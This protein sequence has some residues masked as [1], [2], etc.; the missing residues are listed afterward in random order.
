VHTLKTLSLVLLVVLVFGLSTAMAQS[1]SISPPS[2]SVPVANTLQFSATTSGI[3]N[4][5]CITFPCYQVRWSVNGIAGGNSTV[6]TVGGDGLYTAPSAVPNP[7]TVTV[8]ATSISMPTKSASATVTI[9]ASLVQVSI[10]PTTLAA[11]LGGIY[12]FS[13]TVTGAA[14]TAVTWSVNGIVGGNSTVGTITLIG[15]YFAPSVRPA[16][17]TVTITATSVADPSKSATSTVTFAIPQVFISPETVSV[18]LGLKQQFTATISAF[19]DPTMRWTVNGVLGGNATVGTITASGLYTAPLAVPVPNVVNVIATSVADPTK[20]ATAMVTIIPI[21][22]RVSI[23]PTAV[24]LDTG[25]QQQFTAAVSGSDNTGVIWSVNGIRGGTLTAGTI[26]QTGLYTAPATRPNIGDIPVTATSVADPN[27]SAT[28]LVTINL[29]IIDPRP[30]PAVSVGIS[31][32][33]VFVS[34]GTTEQFS[35][36]AFGV[37]GASFRWSVNNSVGG[38]AAIGTITQTGLYMAPTT[39]I[40]F[41]ISITA[42]LI[43]DPT[44]SATAS[45][46]IIPATVLISVSPRF[47]TLD[48][49]AS[50]RFT[51]TVTGAASQFVKWAVNGFDGGSAAVGTITSDGLYTAPQRT[52]S[53]ALVRITATS[54]DNP[55]ASGTAL[56][57]ISPVTISISPSSMI[58]NT[59]AGASQR[60]FA[61]VSGT[62]NKAVR[63]TV[64]GVLGAVTEYGQISQDGYYIAPQTT[65]NPSTVNVTVTSLADP[66][67]SA[68]AKVFLKDTLGTQTPPSG[69]SGSLNWRNADIIFYPGTTSVKFHL[70][71][72]YGFSDRKIFVSMAVIGNPFGWGARVYPDSERP[73]QTFYFGDHPI[74]AVGAEGPPMK[75]GRTWQFKITLNQMLPD[76]PA[77]KKTWNGIIRIDSPRA[78]KKGILGYPVSIPL[79][80]SVIVNFAVAD[81]S[82]GLPGLI[83]EAPSLAPRDV[84]RPG[85]GIIQTIA[86]TDDPTGYIR[87]GLATQIN[88]FP[89]GNGV[90]DAQGNFYFSDRANGAE[91]VRKLSPSGDLSVYAGGLGSGYSGDGGPA[92]SALLFGPAG[93]AM[94]SA[95]NLY[96][97]DSLNHRVRKVDSK[98]T[99]TTVAG[100]GIPLSSGDNGPALNAGIPAP[101][102]LAIDSVGNLYIAEAQRVR[103][104]APDGT[105]VTVAGI[106][107]PGVDTDNVPATTTSLYV[108]SIALDAAGDLYIADASGTTDRI[109]KVDIASGML[110]T[111]AGTGDCCSSSGDGGPATAAVFGGGIRAL[112]FDSAGNLYVADGLSIRK[113]G[114]DGVVHRFAGDGTDGSDG[115][116]GPATAARLHNVGGLAVDAAGNVFIADF[117]RIREVG[118]GSGTTQIKDLVSDTGI[119]IGNQRTTTMAPSAT[120]CTLP[121][122][123]T[124]FLLSDKTVYLYLDG[125][126]T[127][128][129]TLSSDWRA[130]D[131]AVIPGVT[132][133]VTAGSHCFTGSSLPIGSLSILRQGSW[134]AR[135]YADG[136]LLFSLPFTVNPPLGSPS[137]GPATTRPFLL[138]TSSGLSLLTDF[139][140]GALATGYGKVQPD[141][142]SATPDGVAIYNYRQ[143]GVLVSE[144]AVPANPAL[145]GGRIY[146][147]VNGSVNTGIAIVNAN[148][149]DVSVD[150]YFTDVNGNNFG[151]GSTVIPANG[152][153]ARFL[154]EAPF[155]LN[156][157]FEGTFT[158]IASDPVAAIALRIR[159]NERSE[160]LFTTLP[161]ANLADADRTDDLLFP[162]FADGNGW[163]TQIALV[164]PG[165]T[166]STGTVQFTNPA[167]G[168]QPV[169]VGG[170]SSSSFGYTLP[171]RAVVRLQTSGTAA[172][173]VSGTVR[174]V[175]D[176]GMS[177]PSGLV[178]FA[179]RNG[180]VVVSEAGVP[181]EAAGTAFRLF[182]ET[183]G[184][185]PKS[186]SLQ[187]GVAIT[188]P[189]PGAAQVS[190]QLIPAGGGTIIRGNLSIPPNGQVAK[191]LSEIPGLESLPSEFQGVLRVSSV[192]PISVVGLRGRYNERADFLMSAAAAV[193]DSAFPGSQP[194]FFPHF[195]FGGGFT[196]QFILLGPQTGTT[197]SGI[198]Q[199]FSD[200]GIPLDLPVR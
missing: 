74:D 95:G 34:T 1:V 190:L 191:F 194:S 140:Q 20:Y 60:F 181:S 187:T 196:T 100:N 125:V 110:T 183:S 136:V 56:V 5:T 192:S 40:N 153:I 175:P 22:V 182:A 87:S 116:G 102:S 141:P 50:Q 142:G 169:D 12:G 14:N 120:S 193:D 163:F 25:K 37:T 114:T 135:V 4:V 104:V 130:P 156:Q 80:Q 45:V 149:D 73:N 75:D 83:S 188:N 79:N 177:A 64:N 16:G 195:V 137:G 44:K 33:D 108:T 145:I 124:A 76:V 167:G 47:I 30:G 54:L 162:Q 150:F 168:P 173:T 48:T 71:D 159:T 58:L 186:G 9:T 138:S 121:D 101:Q 55:K 69:S 89:Q 36:T 84:A 97:A 117:N 82:M 158:F 39:V 146:A 166:T 115:D 144:A 118:A 126:A 49:A 200:S 157:N 38:Y 19:V 28:A 77:K 133:E 184:S 53:P 129:L 15:T 90:A 148:D 172:A 170:T 132:W 161:V 32:T 27:A 70:D 119:S 111:I 59:G 31:P 57:T 171:P 151:S 63:W 67:I 7:A 143:N 42:T 154:T 94:D 131:G 68:T 103:V 123:V 107:Q 2:A 155:N 165:N 43:S 128:N 92:T 98:G 51:A 174:V 127:R 185:F 8:T 112:A 178:I 29:V 6:G 122:S 91:V 62:A 23:A 88:V 176:T 46:T 113:I 189:S 198:L 99:I 41:P 160:T 85:P 93:L 26:T 96:I 134:T 18:Q 66:T 179:F 52:P 86:G 152:K 199:F 180:G 24:A 106:G 109:R 10:S 21:P 65:P 3:P 164:N 139:D 78:L 13:A 81:G 105:I 72:V 197:S 61:T 11:D 17:G 35:A 147:S